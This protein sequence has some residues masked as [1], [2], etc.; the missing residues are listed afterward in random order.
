MAIAISGKASHIF[1]A[2]FD[3]YKVDDPHNDE[4]NQIFEI[5]NKKYNKDFL[6]SLTPT[7]YS[8]KYKP[9]NSLKLQ[10]VKDGHYN[11]SQISV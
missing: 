7:K 9:I 4:T 10:Y 8:L 2:G 6:I 3:G 5:L 11:S 1:L